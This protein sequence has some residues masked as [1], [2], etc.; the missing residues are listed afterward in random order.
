MAVREYRFSEQP[1]R[2]QRDAFAQALRRAEAGHP[3]VDHYERSRCYIVT[4]NY[5][6]RAYDRAG[7]KRWTSRKN[8]RSKVVFQP[9]L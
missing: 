9:R 2:E 3:A 1:E 6:R 8:D 7:L 5:L 4:H